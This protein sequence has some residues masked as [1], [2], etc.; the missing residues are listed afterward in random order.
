[1][2]PR[3]T[4]SKGQ[5]MKTIEA[6]KRAAVYFANLTGPILEEAGL[7][8]HITN[9]EA[10][11]AL[12]AT[13]P[14]TAFDGIDIE[15]S[16]SYETEDCGYGT[17]SFVATLTPHR[18]TVNI[19]VGDVYRPRIIRVCGQWRNLGHPFGVRRAIDTATIA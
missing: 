6:T 4:Q 14:T 1:M 5:K 13:M 2:R 16:D 19:G 18:P 15:I 3:N 8:P 17:W 7:Q 11:A 10:L 12:L 9:R